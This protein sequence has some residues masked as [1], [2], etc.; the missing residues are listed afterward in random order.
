MTLWVR[1]WP[2]E[3]AATNV[4]TN[5]V[6]RLGFALRAD[7]EFPL[8]SQRKGGGPGAIVTHWWGPP[9]GSLDGSR[10]GVRLPDLN[11][12]GEVDDPH[13]RLTPGQRQQIKSWWTQ[14]VEWDPE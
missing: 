14:V 11:E 2:T 7:G 12:A 9:V 3:Q 6:D 5:V 10:W 4:T 1:E 13:E 8:A